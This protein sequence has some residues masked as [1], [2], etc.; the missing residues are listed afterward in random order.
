MRNASSPDPG[1]RAAPLGAGARRGSAG[2]IPPGRAARLPIVVIVPDRARGRGRAGL[3]ARPG[4]RR[5]P[6]RRGR[7]RAAKRI[8]SREPVGPGRAVLHR[9]LVAASARVDLCSLRTPPPAADP[10]SDARARYAPR[11]LAWRAAGPPSAQTAPS[12]RVETR[13]DADSVGPHAAVGGTGP[14]RSIGPTSCVDGPRRRSG[15]LTL[16][17][18]PVASS[19]I[20]SASP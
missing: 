9:C 2:A 16:R 14:D 7:D 13:P 3:S 12:R 8:S 10:P 4:R 11:A 1:L 17:A 15:V 18:Q 19:S 5:G 20:A 6:A